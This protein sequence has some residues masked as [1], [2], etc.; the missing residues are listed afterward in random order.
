MYGAAAPPN[1]TRVLQRPDTLWPRGAWIC[2]SQRL[3][4]SRPG[5]GLARPGAPPPPLRAT[6]YGRAPL[7][8][9]RA[10]RAGPPWR[11]RG[12][13]SPV[14]EWWAV[15]SSVQ[16][17]RQSAGRRSSARPG[18]SSPRRALGHPALAG[19]RSSDETLCRARGRATTRRRGHRR[20]GDWRSAN[21]RPEVPTRAPQKVAQNDQNDQTPPHRRA[22]APRRGRRARS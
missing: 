21:G 16:S 22:P 10:S 5:K 2:G 9:A 4:Q 18:I 19:S 17:R 6:R 20:A 15:A 8:S 12:R 13:R 11:G 14:A 1:A 7:R 3:N